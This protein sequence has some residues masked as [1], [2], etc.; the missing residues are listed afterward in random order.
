MFEDPINYFQ[1]YQQKYDVI[2]HELFPIN[3]EIYRKLTQLNWIIHK[4]RE[5]HQLA[6]ELIEKDQ[7]S[8]VVIGE[9]EIYTESFYHFAF[10]LRDILKK[11]HPRFH[12]FEAIGVRD[13][14]NHLIVHP[15]GKKESAK[16]IP[17]FGFSSEEN[18]GPK[19]KG[20]IGP[21]GS[22]ED[23]GLFINAEEFQNELNRILKGIPDEADA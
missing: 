16:T 5:C 1:Q 3:G 6:V 15:E 19:I 20:Y 2:D 7:V 14:R 4:A 21:D 11:R 22:T 18:V 9:L 13:V 17:S 23:K 10:R 12:S 8:F